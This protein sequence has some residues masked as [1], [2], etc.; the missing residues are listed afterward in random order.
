MLVL[1][2]ERAAIGV[3]GC[4]AGLCDSYQ[5]VMGVCEALHPALERLD[6]EHLS[7]FKLNWVIVNMHIFHATIL[8]DPDIQDYGQLCK[9]KVSRSVHLAS[10]FPCASI[11]PLYFSVATPYGSSRKHHGI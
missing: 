11:L 5:W 3:G 2:K 1:N 8:T 6:T 4:G 9:Q 7:R 10:L